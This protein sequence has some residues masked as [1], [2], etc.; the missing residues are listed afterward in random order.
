MPRWLYSLLL[1]CA[2]PCVAPW[3]LWK[4]RRDNQAWGGLR[5]RLAF[6]L[7]QRADHPLWLHAAS[8]G[9]MRSLAVLL[10]QLHRA[11][12]PLLLTVGTMT[13]VAQARAFY[14]DLAKPPRPERR[15]LSVQAAPWDLPFAVRRF[16]RAN[17]PLAGVFV[18]T[19]L[20]P[21]LIAA[22]R[23][24][25]VPLCLVSARLTERSLHGYLRWAPPVDARH[26][27]FLHQ[28]RRAERD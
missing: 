14:R 10:R 13:G 12:F 26:G 21:N 7:V 4:N 16:L 8:V 22:A 17:Q 5:E 9:E 11:G 18:E 3:F 20:W 15:G 23:H 19:E 28:H 27:V 24:A 25:N 1:Y 6:G 2:L